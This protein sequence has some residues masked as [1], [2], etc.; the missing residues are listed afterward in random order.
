[1][2]TSVIE[3][4]ATRRAP[5][6]PGACPRAR[7]VKPTALVVGWIRAGA[8]AGGAR[9]GWRKTAA[10]EACEAEDYEMVSATLR[11]DYARTLS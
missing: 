7:E 6:L 4:G 2:Q 5:A 1:M 3:D 10:A 11:F 8:T 9:F